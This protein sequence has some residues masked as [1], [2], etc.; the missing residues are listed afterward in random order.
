MLQYSFSDIL[1]ALLA[2][3]GVI[4]LKMGP[5]YHKAV[6]NKFEKLMTRYMYVFTNVKSSP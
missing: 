3:N 2:L 4:L 5:D 1:Y 6:D